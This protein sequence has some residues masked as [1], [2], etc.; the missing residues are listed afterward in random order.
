[1]ELTILWLVFF[2]RW[3]DKEAI[4]YIIPSS[5][6]YITNILYRW[7]NL[8]KFKNRDD[9]YNERLRWELLQETILFVIYLHLN[10]HLTI[11]KFNNIKR[12]LFLYNVVALFMVGTEISRCILDNKCSSCAYRLDANLFFP[13]KLAL[14]LTFRNLF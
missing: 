11:K 13:Y 3:V 6:I 5:E 7:N 8:F 9:R 1:M 10:L 2:W 12:A 4:I 14:F